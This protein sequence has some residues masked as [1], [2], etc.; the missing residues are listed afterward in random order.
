MSPGVQKP[1]CTAPASA[2]AC[3]TGCRPPP[4]AAPSIAPIA[5]SPSTVWMSRSWACPAATRHAQT[6]TPSMTT[7][8]D[9]HSPCSQAFL[10][11]GRPS[12]S[13]ST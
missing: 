10:L 6:V 8:H 7:V 3:C 11:P 2:N 9:P 5:A 13:R 4:A 1:H 12:R